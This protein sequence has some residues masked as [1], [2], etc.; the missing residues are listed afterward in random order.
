MKRDYTLLS[1]SS[2]RASCFWLR[3]RLALVIVFLWIFTNYYYLKYGQKYKIPK[4]SKPQNLRNNIIATLWCRHIDSRYICSSL[5]HLMHRIELNSIIFIFCYLV[6]NSHNLVLYL[7]LTWL[8][9]NLPQEKFWN[10]WKNPGTGLLWN[11][12]YVAHKK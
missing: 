9:L 3:G 1:R 7:M 10:I 12:K 8:V 11:K 6:G 5:T 4:Y 2:L